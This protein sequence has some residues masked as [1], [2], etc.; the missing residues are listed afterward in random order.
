[1]TP[2]AVRLAGCC[3]NAS[4]VGTQTGRQEATMRNF[5]R[6]EL[7]TKGAVFSPSLQL[8]RSR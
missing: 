3:A 1:M 4:G 7:R 8:R 5:L 2:P 6:I